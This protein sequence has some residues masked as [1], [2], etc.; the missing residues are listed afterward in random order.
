MTTT[1]IPSTLTPQ[2]LAL[3]ELLHSERFN[4]NAL[5]NKQTP[6]HPAQVSILKLIEWVKLPH[7]ASA[8]D[9]I[10]ATHRILSA[11]ADEEAQLIAKKSLS[12]ALAVAASMIPHF[13]S[14]P[15]D[16][17]Q[18]ELFTKH[19]ETLI[20]ETRLIARTLLKLSPPS[21]PPRSR[22]GRPTDSSKIDNDI[23]SDATS[24]T[25]NPTSSDA[26]TSDSTESTRA[27]QS[28]IRPASRGAHATR[29]NRNSRKPVFSPAEVAEIL[30]AL[31]DHEHD[32]KSR[33]TSSHN[34]TTSPDSSRDSQ[35]LDASL[36]TASAHS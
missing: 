34:P 2:D 28:T 26:A 24:D 32:L 33:N 22:R 16:P 25:D 30:S 36:P 12:H 29:L 11:K 17:E 21:P 31:L 18:A 15:D 14:C 23:A 10:M 27:T 19:T 8:I 35:P 1:Q 4:L 20:R 3:V 7:I 6:F 13:D 9:A 5:L